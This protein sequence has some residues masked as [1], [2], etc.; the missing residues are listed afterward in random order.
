MASDREEPPHP[1]DTSLSQ[2]QAKFWACSFPHPLSFSNTQVQ[3][4]AE[5]STHKDHATPCSTQFSKHN[6]FSHHVVPLNEISFNFYCFCIKVGSVTKTTR[7]P[8]LGNRV[9]NETCPRHPILYQVQVLQHV[10]RKRKPWL[11]QPPP[12]RPL[13]P[14]PK[15][16]TSYT[17][18]P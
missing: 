17:L 11:T 8:S 15:P 7:S 12:F 14:I 3:Q 13:F 5:E 9:G 10:R 16:Q 18:L 1:P 4:V 6:H 2:C